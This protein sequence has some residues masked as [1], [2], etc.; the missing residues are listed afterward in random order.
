[1]FFYYL[2]LVKSYKIFY[3]KV[4]YL[5]RKNDNNENYGRLLIFV[6]IIIKL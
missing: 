3:N 2:S 6:C 1:M 4:T 5:M